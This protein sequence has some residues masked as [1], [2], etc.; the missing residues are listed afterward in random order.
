VGIKFKKYSAHG[1]DFI[2]IDQRVNR[3]ELNEKLVQ[4]LCH[5]NLGIG[6][7][8][9]ILIDEAKGDH[10]FSMSIWNCDGSVADMCGN[11]ARISVAY[12]HLITQKTQFTFK[13]LNSVYE[14]YFKDG[15]AIIKMSEVFDLDAIDI[16][17]LAPLGGMYLNT[18]VAHTVIQV[19]DIESLNINSRGL[20]IRH[21]ERFEGG[22]NVCFFE[23]IRSGEIKFRV[24]E[25][26]VEGETMCCG[27]GIV[28]T[29]ITCK[30]LFNWTGEILVHCLGGEVKVSLNDDLSRI[31][32]Q[33]RVDLVFEGEF[34]I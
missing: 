11:A 20:L 17:D 13:T 30:E 18:G 28:A 19:K 5:R 16:T 2:L 29:A 4:K 14:G 7:D 25:K 12:S 21:D 3:V 15:E 33:G 1:N 26:G 9:I 23:P 6:G 22:T 31:L 8:G 10:D 32:Y 24:F 34:K 27:T